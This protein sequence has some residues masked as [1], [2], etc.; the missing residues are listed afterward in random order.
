[1]FSA[2]TVWSA[3]SD[4]YSDFVV[5]NPLATLNYCRGRMYFEPVLPLNAFA[6][7]Q[8]TKASSMWGVEC[9]QR[10]EAGI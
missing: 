5:I 2:P 1:M 3:E 7:V 6:T 9:L 8:C 10:T 4:G